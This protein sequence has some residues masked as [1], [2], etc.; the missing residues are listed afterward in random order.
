M[1]I[2]N[3]FITFAQVIR[4]NRHIKGRASSDDVKKDFLNPSDLPVTDVE[5]NLNET[6]LRMNIL[7]K[8]VS[9]LSSDN[10]RINRTLQHE[11]VST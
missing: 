10:N 4:N 8:S 7:E 11:G 9:N 1:C 3:I 6:L 5:T 2:S